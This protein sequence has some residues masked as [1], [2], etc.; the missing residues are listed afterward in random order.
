MK[1][2][3][4]FPLFAEFKNFDSGRH[5]FTEGMNLK[6]YYAGQALVGILSNKQMSMAIISMRDTPDE[7]NIPSMVAK[8][9][10]EIADE[11]IK[12]T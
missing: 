7:E 9:A 8:L 3:P 11:M 2:K 1:N 12:S 6:E 5:H 10:W 4:A